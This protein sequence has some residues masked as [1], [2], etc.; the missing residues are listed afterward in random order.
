MRTLDPAAWRRWR[1]KALSDRL[2]PAPPEL[3]RHIA[4]VNDS[5]DAAAKSAGLTLASATQG[6]VS[7]PP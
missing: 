7:A 4:R 2:G 1:G 6:T 3:V 5:A